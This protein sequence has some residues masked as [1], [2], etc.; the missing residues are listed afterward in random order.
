MVLAV[1]VSIATKGA[2]MESREH[3]EVQA[4]REGNLEDLEASEETADGVRGGA[5]RKD[6]FK[7]PSAGI[8]AAG[9]SPSIVSPNM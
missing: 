7:S 6:I 3:E 2:I 9:E 4:E 1:H 8:S 5:R